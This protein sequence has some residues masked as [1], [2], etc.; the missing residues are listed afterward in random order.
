MVRSP[1]G[2]T[3]GIGASESSG[4]GHGEENAATPS[5]ISFPSCS[6]RAV[7]VVSERPTRSTTGRTVIGPACGGRR[8]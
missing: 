3:S 8:K 7:A 2:S 6:S 5:A 1:G 4:P